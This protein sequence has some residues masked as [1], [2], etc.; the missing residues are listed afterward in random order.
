LKYLLCIELQI[1]LAQDYGTTKQFKS[2]NTHSLNARSK[3]QLTLTL[4]KIC[5]LG[6]SAG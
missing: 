6:Y 3:K 4:R 1:R 2:K 5:S